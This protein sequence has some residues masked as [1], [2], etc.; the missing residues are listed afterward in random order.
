M[1]VFNII[2]QDI[3][4]STAKIQYKYYNYQM[5]KDLKSYRKL[6]KDARKAYEA[7]KTESVAQKEYEEVLQESELKDCFVAGFIEGVGIGAVVMTPLLIISAIVSG[8]RA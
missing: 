6:W 5:K 3:K 7:V 4:E 1:K 8:T 2:K